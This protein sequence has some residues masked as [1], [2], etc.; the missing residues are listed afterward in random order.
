MA[1]SVTPIPTASTSHRG[2]KDDPLRAALRQ[3]IELAAAAK[4]R[5]ERHRGA[6]ARAE[7]LV[8]AAEE[9]H[10][11]ANAAL[12]RVREQQASQVAAATLAGTAV[13]TASAMRSARS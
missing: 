8:E 12:D 1:A 2:G 7:G 3:A 11:A 13:S 9:K 4:L 5:V 6:I 10:Q